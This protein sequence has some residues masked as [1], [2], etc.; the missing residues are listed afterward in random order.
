[1]ALR[2]E[3]ISGH[4]QRLGERRMKEFGVDGGTIGRSLETDWILPDPER[5]VSSRHASIDFRSGSYYLVDTSM[6]GVYVNDAE[7]PVGRGKPQRLFDG[8]MLRIGSYRIRVSIDEVDSTSEQLIDSSH[9]DPVDLAQRVPPPDP[10][11][12]NLIDE[13]EITGVGIDELLSEG[14][15]ANA[16]KA[17]AQRRAATLK[18]EGEESARVPAPPASEEREPAPTPAK[19]ARAVPAGDN[20]STRLN[21]FFRG[22]GLQ[23]R[24]LDEAQ[25]D[26]TLHLLGQLMRELILGITDNLHLR[27]EQKNSLRLPHT[28]IQRRENNPLKFSAG[29]DEALN[30]LFFREASEYMPAVDAVRQAFGDIRTHQQALLASMLVALIDYMERLDPDELERKFTKGAKRPG[31]IGAA[32]KL[33]YWDLYRDLYQVMTQHA[34]GHFPPAFLEELS[35]SYEEEAERLAGAQLRKRQA[36]AG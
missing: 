22:A 6:N 14:A 7:Q 25:S 13:Y 26:V 31:L 9:V 10:T 20:G 24:P 34:P 27:A 16:L 1:M 12:N 8:D 29:V 4:R 17:A 35:R 30:N 15:E 18:L 23:P 19:P 28:T 2:L 33:K 36:N 3:V 11:A 21:A 5:Y 32:S